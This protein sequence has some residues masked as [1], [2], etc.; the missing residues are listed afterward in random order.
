MPQT[1]DQVLALRAV[2]PDG[3]SKWLRWSFGVHTGVIVLAIVL[4]RS[5][6]TTDRTPPELMTISLGGGTP[7]PRSTGQTAISSRAVD[8]AVP[9]PPRPVPI[10][11]AAT[12]PPPT[13]STVAL[14]EPPKPVTQPKPPSPVTR[15]PTTGAQVQSG[16]AVA[17]TGAQTP[18]AGLS[19]GGGGGEAL[20]DADFC[21]KWYLEEMADRV[22]GI[23]NAKLP[24]V[25]GDTIIQFAISR[26]GTI[27][28]LQVMKSSGTMG[29]IEARLALQNV[30]LNPMPP[31]IDE[32][33]I[34]IRLTFPYGRD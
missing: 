9:T 20:V 32:P 15:P 23:W 18:S 7:G 4:P 33:K 26:D 2:V 5:W 34:V 14:P 11:P 24:G 8:E 6:I 21:C 30:K 10:Q 12:R 16:T 1:V 28:E 29:D 27:G 31:Q 13:A 25:R 22:Q 3:L 19:F 17:E